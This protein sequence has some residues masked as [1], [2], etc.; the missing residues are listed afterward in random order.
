[1]DS[2]ERL[3]LSEDFLFFAV[4]GFT[5]IIYNYSMNDTMASIFELNPG[6]SGD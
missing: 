2:R 6:S 1:M 3:N 5:T 4:L